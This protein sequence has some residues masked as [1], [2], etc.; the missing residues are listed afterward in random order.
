MKR[1]C[2]DSHEQGSASSDPIWVASTNGST[3][4]P[5]HIEV[6]R[7]MAEVGHRQA[8]TFLPSAAVD[9]LLVWCISAAW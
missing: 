8:A 5:V 2:V 9:I 3:T 4:A 6:T 7:I 1:R